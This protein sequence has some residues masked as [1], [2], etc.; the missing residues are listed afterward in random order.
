M[1]FKTL[2]ASVALAVVGLVATEAGFAA[3]SEAR[4]VT[5]RVGEFQG[6]TAVDRGTYGTDTLYVPFPNSTG[7]V[8][9]TCSTGDYNWNS[10]ISRAAALHIATSWCGY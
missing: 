10:A 5:G 7:V 3:P 6:V 2:A 8:N 1:N 9:V 4:T